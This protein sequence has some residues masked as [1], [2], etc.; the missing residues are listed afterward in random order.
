MLE[1]KQDRSAEELG[2]SLVNEAT[3]KEIGQTEPDG[4]EASLLL[5]VPDLIDSVRRHL[6]AQKP[7]LDDDQFRKTELLSHFF[8]YG[9]GKDL[10][11]ELG[12]LD[13]LHQDTSYISAMW[14]EAFL[15]L[16]DS[17]AFHSNA[18]PAFQAN[19]KP[20]QNDQ[21]TRVTNLTISS[22]QLLKTFRAGSLEPEVMHLYPEK[23]D[24]EQFK[25]LIQFISPDLVCM[26]ASVVST[27]PLDMSQFYR[28]F[29]TTHI[30]LNKDDLVTDESRC[31]FWCYEMEMFMSLMSWMIMVIS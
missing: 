11:E 21:L 30:P 5:P 22:I 25:K 27:Y 23:T 29:N 8:K 17:I 7:I 9:I 24:N 12:T 20:E 31:T 18:A 2:E 28:L 10:H 26:A 6:N 4:G 15:A 3:M 16:R 1:P 13:E 19:P 14:I